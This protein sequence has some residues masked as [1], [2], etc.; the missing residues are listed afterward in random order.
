[1]TRPTSDAFDPNREIAFG[2]EEPGVYDGILY[3]IGTDGY[4]FHRHTE[5]HLMRRAQPWIDTYNRGRSYS[6]TTDKSPETPKT[7]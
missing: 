1:M 5:T 2:V 4:A 3:W 6:D 7:T